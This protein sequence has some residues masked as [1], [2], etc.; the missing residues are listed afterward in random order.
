M[1][2]CI[3]ISETHLGSV[4]VVCTLKVVIKCFSQ[5]L[6]LEFTSSVRLAGKQARS[7]LLPHTPSTEMTGTLSLLSLYVGT[8]IWTQVVRC[9]SQAFYQLNHLPALIQST[10][11]VSI[12]GFQFRDF[13]I[14]ECIW[15]LCPV[16]GSFPY[17]RFVQFGC[18]NFGFI[19]YLIIKKF[20][21]VN[22]IIWMC[23]GNLKDICLFWFTSFIQWCEHWI[24]NSW[25][26]A[27]EFQLCF[28]SEA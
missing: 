10:F 13:M 16:L 24:R 19:F 2:V 5:S 11:C 22:N 28:L 8:G 1:S 21:P 4:C 6:S 15:F 9:A 18:L 17:L 7:A 3:M 23:W 12:N 20:T 26:V 25:V 27:L 14:P